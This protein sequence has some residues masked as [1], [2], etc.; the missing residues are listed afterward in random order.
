MCKSGGQRRSFRAEGFDRVDGGGAARWK[1]AGEE[2]RDDEAKGDGGVGQGI[3]WA[4]LEE[5]GGH[6]AHHDDGGG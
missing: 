6:E 3:D 1:V 5:Q 2:S 4:D